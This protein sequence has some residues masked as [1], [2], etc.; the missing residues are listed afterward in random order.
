MLKTNFNYCFLTRDC[1]LCLLIW[2]KTTLSFLTFYN[3]YFYVSTWIIYTLIVFLNKNSEINYFPWLILELMAFSSL[4]LFVWLNVLHCIMVQ[5]LFV[6][7]FLYTFHIFQIHLFEWYT[8]KVLKPQQCIQGMAELWGGV[9]SG[10]GQE[11]LC[12]HNWTKSNPFWVSLTHIY[13]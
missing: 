8:V 9:K 7:T 1:I 6:L 2:K 4:Q 5:L 10:I 3:V 12:N 13:L 11:S